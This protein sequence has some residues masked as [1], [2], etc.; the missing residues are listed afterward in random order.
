MGAQPWA[1]DSPATGIQP[2]GQMSHTQGAHKEKWGTERANLVPP[3]SR[4]G[5][6]AQCPQILAADSG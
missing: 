6:T 1:P 3:H 4:D 5:V 2:E